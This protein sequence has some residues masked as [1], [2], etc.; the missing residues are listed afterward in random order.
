MAVNRTLR[1]G[2]RIKAGEVIEVFM[3]TDDEPRVVEP[4]EDLKKALA[5]DAAARAVWDKLSYTHRKEFVLAIEDAK[6][7]E[8]RARRVKKTLE[9]LR[10]KK[11]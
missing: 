11:K 10:S 1:E 3:E 5:A 2:A 7:P 6:K 4:P 9:E 8:T